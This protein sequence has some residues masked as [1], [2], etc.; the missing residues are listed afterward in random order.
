MSLPRAEEWT[1]PGPMEPPRRR[2]R[3]AL[4]ASALLMGAVVGSFLIWRT[5]SLGLIPRVSEPFDTQAFGTVDIPDDDNAFTYYRQAVAKFRDRPSLGGPYHSWARASIFDREWL[6]ANTEAMEIWFLGTSMDRAVYVQ[7]KDLRVE[8]RMEVCRTLRRMI[9]LAQLVG[10][11]MEGQGEL[12]EAWVWYRAGLRCSRHCGRNGGFIDR[13]IG[14]SLYERMEKSIRAWADHPNLSPSSLRRALDEVIAINAMTPTLAE[15]LRSE[16]FAF[17]RY[18]DEPD[19]SLVKIDRDIIESRWGPDR[20]PFGALKEATWCFALREPERSR[21]TI[22]LVW[23]NWLSTSDLTA[24]DRRG[25]RLQYGY[26]YLPPADAPE[27]VRRLS[28]EALDRWVG[29]TLY[30]RAVIPAIDSFEKALAQET[31]MRAS[32]VVYLAE[33]LFR[34]EKGRAP[35]SPDQLVGP[36]LKA[37]PE[38]Y[39]PTADRPTATPK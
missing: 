8:S 19:L 28:P 20:T 32:L 18:L 2:G 6:F 35:D 38:G 36:Y 26:F 14:L 11:R 17:S 13:L 10:L 9:A 21:R 25:R 30:L 29:S 4:A 12:D 3:R 24:E 27:A 15:N 22:R 16:Y 7:P 34:L 1:D 23:A 33:Q 5:T 37:L 39:P 31:T